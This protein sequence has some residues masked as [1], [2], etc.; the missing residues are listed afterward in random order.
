MFT[1]LYCQSRKIRSNF[2]CVRYI[3]THGSN[4][5]LCA[6]YKYTFNFSVSST[7]EEIE[8]VTQFRTFKDSSVNKQQWLNFAAKQHLQWLYQTLSHL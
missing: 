2:Q 3:S 8:G 7:V 4:V 6:N 1:A 5:N